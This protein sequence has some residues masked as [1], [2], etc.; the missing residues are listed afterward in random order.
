MIPTGSM[1]EA[2]AIGDINGD[3]RNDVVMT[4]YSY[5]SPS[6]DYKLIVFTQNSSGELNPPVIYT[7]SGAGGNYPSSVAIGDINNDG[8]NEV[9]IGNDGLNIEVFSQDGS[10]GLISSAVYP[11]VNSH[12]IKTD[13]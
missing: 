1:P 6:T 2:V 8:K 11:T 13:L 12:R 5:F 4:T 9:V 10:G 7:T 3:G